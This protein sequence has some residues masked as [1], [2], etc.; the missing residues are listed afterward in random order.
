MKFSNTDYRS[1]ISS[2]DVL[3]D[4]LK[5]TGDNNIVEYFIAP[6]EKSGWYQAAKKFFQYFG[7]GGHIHKACSDRNWLCNRD[8]H[9]WWL[10]LRH[11]P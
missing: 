5:T 11:D 2:D 10:R 1:I 4:I 8:K 3:P 7:L 6:A 9:F